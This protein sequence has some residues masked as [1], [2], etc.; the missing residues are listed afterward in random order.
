MLTDRDRV[1]Y[2]QCDEGAGQFFCMGEGQKKQVVHHSSVLNGLI[3]I[4]FDIKHAF[5]EQL[6]QSVFYF[7]C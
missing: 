7:C 2:S 1:V 3:I 5:T 6:C 4:I